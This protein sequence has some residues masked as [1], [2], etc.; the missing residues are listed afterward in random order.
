MNRAWIVGLLSL[1][2]M[3]ASNAASEFVQEAYSHRVNKLLEL[4]KGILQNPIDVKSIGSMARQNQAKATLMFSKPAVYTGLVKRVEVTSAGDADLIIESGDKF[5]IVVV[6]FPYQVVSYERKSD[7][8]VA[9][10]VGNAMEFASEVN[11]G[12]KFYF[13]CKKAM[14]L[15]GRFY[16][17]DCLA[18]A[19]KIYRWS[20]R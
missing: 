1:L 18:F 10:D 20:S 3:A 2:Y 11:P 15:S 19:P 17:S 6:L 8:W 4:D 9:S 12:D 13:Q 7:G 14:P 16:L 5:D